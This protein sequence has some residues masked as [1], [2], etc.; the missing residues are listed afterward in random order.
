MKNF[1]RVLLTLV[2]AL[3]VFA[4]CFAMVGCGKDD[5][6]KDDKDDSKTS[7][8][9]KKETDDSKDEDDDEKEIAIKKDGPE[10]IADKAMKAMWE[11]QDAQAFVDLMN[12][13]LIAAAEEEGMSEQDMVDSFQTIL[14]TLD[15]SF[16]A[17]D[18]VDITW[19]I[20]DVNDVD[21]LDRIQEEYKDNVDLDV[22]D[23]KVV[24]ITVV[25]SAEVDGKTASQEQEIQLPVVLIDGEWSIDM[26]NMDM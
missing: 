17:A 11:D 14:D 12:D 16:A 9:D 5:D 22:E 10:E 1:K 8:S 13:D 6:K 3:L 15:D 18:A 21:D 23:A 20:G 25:I 19:E 2:A 26:A 7:V 4:M 24:D